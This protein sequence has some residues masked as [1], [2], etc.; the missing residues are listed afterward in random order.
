MPGQLEQRRQSSL[1]A[2]IAANSDQL[3][4]LTLTYDSGA[5]IEV[6]LRPLAAAATAAAAA[7]RPLRLT[8][9]RL[10][11]GGVLDWALVRRLL[12][13]LP[14]LH[15][16]QLSAV[17]ICPSYPDSGSVEEQLA[18]LMHHQQLQ[19]L[20]LGGR[21]THGHSS[22]HIDAAVVA[23]LLPTSLQRLAWQSNFTMAVPDLSHLARLAFLK[24]GH[25][26]GAGFSSSKLPPNLQELQL[27]FVLVD[28]EVLQ[29]HR[30]VL[31]DTDHRHVTA[32]PFTEAADFPRLKAVHIRGL[33][34]PDS[35]AQLSQLTQLS[36]LHLDAM[37]PDGAA[38][39]A[40]LPPI[41]SLS[42]LR[43]VNLLFTG[44]PVARGLGA[45]TAVTRLR[46]TS[47]PLQK[48][49]DQR[50]EELRRHVWAEEVG[51]MS[52]LKWL[53]LPGE[54]VLETAGWL[55]GLQQLQVLVLHSIWVAKR[56]RE[57]AIVE[58]VLHILEGKSSVQ[59]PP[60][61]LMLLGMAG[62]SKRLAEWPGL[63]A[64][65]HR[66]L[67]SSRCEVVLWSLLDVL[68]D[69]AQQLAGL[70]EALQQA[71]A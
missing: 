16:L 62:V 7:G 44:W 40:A 43:S 33:P 61:N 30:Q 69:P 68:A 59:L 70:P 11:G 15:T 31:T 57:A 35:W 22:V 20:N 49:R 46:L 56:Q 36:F 32:Q 5:D 54:M 65:L 50:R 17:C 1:A 24:L 28:A 64:R 6:L 25:W 8:T 19:E 63:R 52:N 3:E 47:C 4:A 38:L 66:L 58:Q 12:A 27:S 23:G 48:K 18:P 67:G 45:L 37:H 60:P 29:E 39:Q 51:Q 34:P 14:H 53:T 21:F 41:A 42:S 71:L 26:R 9:L 2:W 55:G 10:L 13:A